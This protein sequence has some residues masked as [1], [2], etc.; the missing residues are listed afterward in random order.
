MSTGCA[1]PDE[2]RPLIYSGYIDPK[3]PVYYDKIPQ[4]ERTT[5]VIIEK[6]L[7]LIS[8]KREPI[9]QRCIMHP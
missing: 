5:A 1:R 9:S 7:F 2:D 8:K 6:A 3:H 4:K